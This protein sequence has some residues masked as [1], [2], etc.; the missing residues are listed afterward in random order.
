MADTDLRASAPGLLGGLR[1]VAIPHVFSQA[2][3]TSE[4]AIAVGD[5]VV[6]CWFEVETAYNATSTNV[7]IVGDG[8]TT[9]KY[10][11]SS[12]VTEGTPAVY[13]TG[14]KGPYAKETVARTL[15]VGYTQSGTAATTGAGTFY[16]LISS[17]P[18]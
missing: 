12:D 4:S 2:S 1:L 14:G 7:I 15:T 16:A 5:V 9:N 6:Q 17:L 10:L 13:P 11:T 18:E 8:N 3:A